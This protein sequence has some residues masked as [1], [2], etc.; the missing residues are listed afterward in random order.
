[1][2]RIETIEF[3][4]LWA[5]IPL[6]IFLYYIYIRRKKK[7]LYAF[8]DKGLTD[9]I[10][11]ELSFGKQRFKFILIMIAYFFLVLAISNPQ[12]GV[13]M[14]KSKREGS[15]LMICLDIS[16]SMYAEDIKPNRISRAKQALG[17]LVDQLEGDRIG[18]VVFAGNAFVQLP[19]TSDYGAAKTF[20]D[21][22][23]PSMISNQ[24]TAIANA[25]S[26]A[27]S[28]FG[29]EFNNK[30]K[31]IILISDGEDNEEGAVSAARA[32][33]RKGIVINAIGIGSPK[34]ALIPIKTSS[35]KSDYMK[36]S[37]GSYVMTKLNETMLK[38]IAKAG[39]GMYIGANDASISLESIL[40]KINK[41]E[42]NEY[43]A[44]SYNEYESRFHVF[45]FIAFLVLLVEF[46]VFERKNKYINRKFFFGR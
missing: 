36:T 1:M 28:S 8:I 21:I 20:I 17:R 10:I 6:F 4:Y 32:I 9:S 42:K 27:E 34:G 19:I 26:L 43:E 37:D 33:A 18:I 3:L 39:G 13:S 14:E 23:D 45:A 16:N 35:G 44:I 15:D 31:S 25:L 11:P 46:L 5:L 40:A 24:G 12:M 41:M 7:R 2:F 30:S 22:I 38:D 29:E